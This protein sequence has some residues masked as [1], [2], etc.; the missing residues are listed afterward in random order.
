MYAADRAV[1]VWLVRSPANIRPPCVPPSPVGGPH[2]GR[3]SLGPQ[4]EYLGC[5]QQ[6]MTMGYHSFPFGR[7]LLVDNRQEAPFLAKQGPNNACNLP[8]FL[9]AGS[10]PVVAR[11]NHSTQRVWIMKRRY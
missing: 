11:L 3:T 5:Q 8:V 2:T 7:C 4:R 1:S 10:S 6:D 9:Q